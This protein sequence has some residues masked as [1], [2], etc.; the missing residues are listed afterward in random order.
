MSKH[1]AV[2]TQGGS[3][4]EVTRRRFLSIFFG[5]GSALGLGAFAAPLIRYVY[6][7]LKGTVYEKQKIAA[8][9]DVTGDGVRFDYQDIPSMLIQKKDKSYAAF[10]LVCTHLG[11]IVKWEP[12]NFDFHCPCHGGK[13]NENGKNIA[14]PPPKPLTEWNITQEAGQIFVN[15]VKSGG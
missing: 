1:G 12:Q 7:V 10:S 15:G 9:A 4:M 6:P 2:S 3:A 14:G 11:C 5:I 13:F 8:V